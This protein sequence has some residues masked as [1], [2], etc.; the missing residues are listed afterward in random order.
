GSAFHRSIY[1]FT[2]PLDSSSPGS[3]ATAERVSSQGAGLPQFRQHHRPQPCVRILQTLAT[4]ALGASIRPRCPMRTVTHGSTLEWAN[5]SG[6]SFTTTTGSAEGHNPGNAYR[7]LPTGDRGQNLQRA[8]AC[9]EAALRVYTQADFPQ[10]WAMTQNNLG[11][12]YSQM[13]TRDR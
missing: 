8:I 6:G 12:A 10:D 5:S 9:Y 7:G 1:S 4:L 3:A 11:T 2:S 13:P